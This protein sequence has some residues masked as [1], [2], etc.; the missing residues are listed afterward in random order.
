MGRFGDDLCHFGY[1]AAIQTN[2]GQFKLIHGKTNLSMAKQTHLP[3]C[4]LVCRK[5]DSF[6]ALSIDF[7]AKE[8][9]GR[10]RRSEA[11]SATFRQIVS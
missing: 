1:F 7:A 10:S 8:S 5:V 9:I 3:Q 11:G 4:G 2:P 6:A